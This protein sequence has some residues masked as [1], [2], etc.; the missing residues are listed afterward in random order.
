M[1][2]PSSCIA[3]VVAALVAAT[4]L[5]PVLADGSALYELWQIED[6]PTYSFVAETS[7]FTI[8]FGVN[9]AITAT[10]VVG[11]MW[12]EGCMEGGNPLAAAD[13]IL[14][15][16]TA[17]DTPGEATITFQLDPETLSQNEDVFTDLPA[18]AKAQMKF[19]SRFALQTD[20]AS[21]KVNFLEV[22]ITVFFDLTAGFVVEAFAVEP[23][24]REEDTGDKDYAVDAYLCDPAFPDVPL[25]DLTFPQGSLITVCVTP[26]VV[27]QADGIA[28]EKIESFQWVRGFMEQPAIANALPSA[29]QLTN[30]VCVPGS[31][32]C[33]FTSI[34]YAD[35]FTPLLKETL[36]PSQAPTEQ[37]TIC[38]G[39]DAT[40]DTNLNFYGSTVKRSTLQAG[41]ELRYGDIGTVD[42]QPV[43]ILITST[44]YYHPNANANGLDSTGNFGDIAVRVVEGEPDSGKGT[45][46][47]CLVEEDTYTPVTASSFQWYVWM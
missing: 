29:N 4:N 41:G 36:A 33:S 45:L 35:F 27:S 44:D 25:L 13:G 39:V 14:G 37:V 38:E 24:E 16:A 32:V 7:T 3:F 31:I 8:T 26:T 5:V 11:T 21:W 46:D 17:V 9:N 42:G 10:N 34:L 1:T 15:F 6:V 12:E 18:Q 30:Y 47:F 22:I 20:D 23:V 28:M 2:I 43:D 40:P 19:C